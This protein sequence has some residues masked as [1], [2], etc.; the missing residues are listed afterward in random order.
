MKKFRNKKEIVCACNP[1]IEC[2]DNQLLYKTICKL[3]YRH[4]LRQ[5]PWLIHIATAH[6]R[7]MVS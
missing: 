2:A 7:D 4:A 6:H 1:G 3:L 5:V